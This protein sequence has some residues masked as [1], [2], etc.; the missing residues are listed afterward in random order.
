MNCSPPSLQQLC[1]RSV[2][3]TNQ[4][5]DVM[6]PFIYDWDA[7]EFPQNER[8]TRDEEIFFQQLAVTGELSIT[9]CK[10]ALQ[11]MLFRRPCD[12]DLV[13]LKKIPMF[14]GV[15]DSILRVIWADT[16]TLEWERLVPSMLDCKLGWEQMTMTWTIHNKLLDGCADKWLLG[17]LE[18][19]RLLLVEKDE[20]E[21]RIAREKREIKVWRK[22]VGREWLHEMIQ[23]INNYFVLFL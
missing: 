4:L 13:Q 2:I 3:S 10:S 17:A 11:S 12:L 21:E 22:T 20:E 5:L 23:I 9:E 1:V 6:F 7:E 19:E 8:L 14:R 18:R 15:S 16:V